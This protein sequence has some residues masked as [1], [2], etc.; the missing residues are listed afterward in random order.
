MKLKK[1]LPIIVIVLMPLVY[2][3]YVWNKLPAKVPIHWNI[4][5][6]IDNYGDKLEMALLAISLPLI[7]Y[8]LLLVIPAIDP[9]G[10]LKNMGKKYHTIKL[11]LTLFM[12]I[13]ALVIIYSSKN[14]SITNPNYIVLLIGVLYVVFGN[15]FKTIKANYFIGI[16]TPWTLESET[17]WKETHKLGGQMWFIG[18]IVV[19]ASSLLFSKQINFILFS[20]VTAI[21]TITPIVYSYTI[22]NKGAKTVSGENG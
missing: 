14:L 5:G 18:G 12:S 16:R 9:K 22:F 8:L 2:L 7:T 20:I 3:A 19:L 10:K 17:V 4:K 15:F 6:E 11:F 1:E 21:I 13:M